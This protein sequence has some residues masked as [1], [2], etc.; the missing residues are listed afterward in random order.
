M[1]EKSDW[2][3]RLS[4]AGKFAGTARVRGDDMADVLA[5]AALT[6]PGCV[7][8]GIRQAHP[9]EFE[10]QSA[11]SSGSALPAETAL[12]AAMKRAQDQVRLSQR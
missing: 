5:R 6:F 1:T 11:R 12:G 9:G 8:R 7:I 3:V 2:V 10:G 4:R